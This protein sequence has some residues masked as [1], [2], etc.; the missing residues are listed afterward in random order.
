LHEAVIA[1]QA[2]ARAVAFLAVFEEAVATG[3]LPRAATGF[4]LI[5]HARRL[6]RTVRTGATILVIATG[7]AGIRSV[8]HTSVTEP[9]IA[10]IGPKLAMQSAAGPLAVAAARTLREGIYGHR[11]KGEDSAGAGQR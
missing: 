9:E 1:R 4:G 3:S 2:V 11:E 8:R 6:V 10:G 5:T 7:K